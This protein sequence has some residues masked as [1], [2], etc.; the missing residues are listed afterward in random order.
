MQLSSSPIILHILSKNCR[1]STY[2]IGKKVNLSAD[3][4]GLRIKKLCN[5]G[6]IKKFTI[7]PNL[8]LLGYNWYTFNLKIAVFDKK[9][10]ARFK[11]F[12]GD[13]PYIIKAIKTLGMCDLLMYIIA[14]GQEHFHK[15]VKQIKKEF[16]DI[17]RNYGTFV[18]YR[19]H[20]FRAMPNVLK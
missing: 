4:V 19:E 10:E 15:T 7:L 2:E 11:I 13:H 3:A 8:S 18:A 12:I 20:M 17:I 6:I 5:S 16:S 9:N 1:Q 14:D